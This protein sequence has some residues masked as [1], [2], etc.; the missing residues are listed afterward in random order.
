MDV[1][2]LRTFLLAS[3][4]AGYAGAEEKKWIKEANSSTTIRFTSGEWSS[5]DNFFG[6]EP[7]GGRT[8]VFYKGKPVWMMVYY[9][10]IDES[11]R[12]P[13]PIYAF[14]RQALMNMPP[15]YPF[16]GP[17]SLKEKKLAYTNI[18]KGT[19]ER[20]AGHENIKEGG[21]EV[22]Y[23]SYVGGLIDQQVAL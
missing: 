6:G 20:F 18:W 16:R 7:Y 12:D 19:I 8:I 3:N 23:A 13:N 4:K 2:A 5:D 11:V 1:S 9:G 21:K 14:L 15:D 10:W 17:K 22:Y